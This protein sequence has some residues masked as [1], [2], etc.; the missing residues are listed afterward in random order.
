MGVQ[1]PRSPPWKA[2]QSGG[3]RCFER[4]WLARVGFESSVFRHRE[5]LQIFTRVQRLALERRPYIADRAVRLGDEYAFAP[6]N[7]LIPRHV[8]VTG[9]C[10]GT[11]EA[12]PHFL[13]SY[14]TNGVIGANTFR[15]IGW[16][17]SIKFLPTDRRKFDAAGRANK[18][19]ELKK[20]E[21]VA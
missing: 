12:P 11:A 18:K 15:A 20:M 1:V 4:R 9:L 17:K 19:L 10:Y 7:G 14:V 5:E 8:H 6:P 2:N 16:F 13:V 21:Q 3:W